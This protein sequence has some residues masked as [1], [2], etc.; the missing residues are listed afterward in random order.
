LPR[1]PSAAAQGYLAEVRAAPR[2]CACR[3]PP[4]PCNR[5]PVGDWPVALSGLPPLLLL[6]LLGLLLVALLPLLLLL[7][8]ALLPLLLLLLVALLPLLLLLLVAL[9]PLLLLLLVVLA[10]LPPDAQLPAPHLLSPAPAR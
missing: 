8:V 4:I 5:L 7:L 9:L 2:R 6:L 10:E 3:H 1:A